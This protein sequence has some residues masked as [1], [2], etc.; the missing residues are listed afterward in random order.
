[1]NILI[2]M[3][4]IKINFSYSKSLVQWYFVFVVLLVL[5]AAQDFYP[6]FHSADLRILLHKILHTHLQEFTESQASQIIRRV[7]RVHQKYDT[8]WVMSFWWRP[9]D[10]V[11]LLPHFIKALHF[12]HFQ[13][14]PMG[15]GQAED[16]HFR[17][18][19]I[20]NVNL[21]VQALASFQSL[22]QPNLF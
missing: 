22:L 11:H 8:W 14:F 4:K 10:E 12:L 21:Q 5:L 15:V 13:L 20:V 9:P 19:Q 7:P 16:A 2:K 17:M 6:D 3:I 1:M 18:P